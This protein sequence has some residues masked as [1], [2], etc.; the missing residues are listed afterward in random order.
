MLRLMLNHHPDICVPAETWFFPQLMKHAAIYGNFDTDD[1][2]ERFGQ[3]VATSPVEAMTPFSD[4]FRLPAEAIV[5]AV[6]DYG[7]RCYAQAFAAILTRLAQSE[8]KTCWGEKTPFYSSF[9]PVL[10]KCYP[11]ARF[12]ALV[13]DPRDVVA[14]LRRT[15]W[16][17]AS[18]PTIVDAAKRWRVAID[19]IDRGRSNSAS[20]RIFMLRYEDLVADP[21]AWSRN[22]CSFLDFAFDPA[23]IQFHQDAGALISESVVDWHQNLNQPIS[24]KHVGCFRRELSTDDT[25]LVER[26][27]S[28][29]LKRFGYS[30]EG[31]RLPARH[32]GQI[33]IWHIRQSYRSLRGRRD[34]TTLVRPQRQ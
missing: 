33:A 25:G 7:A 31:R 29:M 13:R 27:C 11:R 20:D 9:L 17:R 34:W 24:D 3:D 23:M 19:D 26:I 10:V 21:D 2:I 4:A 30:A 1:G 22:I 6:R 18:Y 32:L 5:R 12:L 15:A 16:G 28:P 8:G 14:S